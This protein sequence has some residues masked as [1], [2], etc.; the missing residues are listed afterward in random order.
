[1][2]M[3]SEE[4]EIC[5][6]SIAIYKLMPDSLVHVAVKLINLRLLWKQICKSH[7]LQHI[8]EMML[9]ELVVCLQDLFNHMGGT[10]R[11]Q[12]CRSLDCNFIHLII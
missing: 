3:L 6:C 9:D 7:Y 10:L 5:A 12:I 4:W 1:M 11:T 2:Y 8:A